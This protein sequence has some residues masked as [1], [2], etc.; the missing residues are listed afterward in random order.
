MNG[1]CWLITSQVNINFDA[2]EDKIM[3]G[4][5]RPD[6]NDQ[7]QPLHTVKGM[8][9]LISQVWPEPPPHGHLHVLVGRPDVDM[10]PSISGEWFFSLLLFGPFGNT[11]CSDAVI[12]PRYIPYHVL[13]RSNSPDFSVP[14]DKPRP[15]SRSIESTYSL[16][17]SRSHLSIV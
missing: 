2:V 15:G 12:C 14:F 8:T 7:F 11:L 9:S 17:L 1:L 10:H 4:E 16:F 5:Y 6:A 3:R 13:C